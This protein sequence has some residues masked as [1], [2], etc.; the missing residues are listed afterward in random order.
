MLEQEN[1]VPAIIGKSKP[2]VGLW[3]QQLIRFSMP[4]V[5]HR[6]CTSE[7]GLLVSEVIL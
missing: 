7:L 1:F 5:V 6:V 2:T 4:V 3:V